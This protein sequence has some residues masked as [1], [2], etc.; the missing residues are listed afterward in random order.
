MHRRRLTLPILLVIFGLL[1]SAVA[2]GFQRAASTGKLSLYAPIILHS[3]TTVMPDGDPSWSAPIA[4]SPIDATLWVVNPDAG[5]VTALD[6]RRLTKIAEIPVGRDPWALAISPDGRSV[7]VVDRA[8]GALVVVDTRS[9]VVRARLPVGPEPAT[10]ALSPTG[11]TAYVTLEASGELALVDTASL[12]VISRVTVGPHPYAI[13][14]SDDGDTDDGDER[15]YV[16]HLLARARPGAIEATDDGREGYISVLD[17]GTHAVV[18]QIALAPDTHGFPNL[19][20]GIA[21]ASGRAWVPQ[22]RAAPALPNGLTTTVFA[23]VSALDLAADSEDVAARLLL[24]DQDVFGSP[25]NNPVA[26]VPAPDGKTLY[27]I[28]AGSNLVEVVDVADPHQPRLIK[29]LPAGNNPRGIAISADRQRGYVMSYLSRSVTVLDLVQLSVI[30]EVPVT[31][32]TLEPAVLRGKLLF[33][34]AADPRMA[35]VSWMSCASCH[36][37][38]GTDGVTWMF[39]DGPRQT[40]QLWNA[41]RT[42][43]WHWSAALDEAQDV[44]VTIEKIQLGLGLITGGEPLLLGAP[45]AG[46]SSDLDALAAYLERGIRAPAIPPPLSDISQGRALFASAGCVA[47]HGGPQWTTSALPGPSGT[48]DPD[49]NGMVDALLHDVG[50][51]DTRD[52]RGATGFDSPSLLDVGLTAPYLHNG[53]MPTLEALMTS[54]HPDPIGHGN[55]LT[56]DEITA[57][58]AFLRSIGPGTIPVANP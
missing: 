16:T 27:I 52:V 34:S 44:E 39:P 45:S 56:P 24:N 32:E 46:R 58:V 6:T 35:R 2:A 10:V 30:G 57:L 20:A 37:D 8:G 7:Y 26:A 19:L 42:L 28:L 40:P 13:A 22:V 4:R 29:F 31:T 49:D 55:R 3:Y 51:L 43:P 12:T 9:L 36:A 25:V 48:L 54:G 23:S 33:N 17:A 1:T 11:A 14:V 5:S 50:T 18:K 41:A 47:C 15:V 38:G 53:S 21:I